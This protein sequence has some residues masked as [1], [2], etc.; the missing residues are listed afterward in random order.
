[1]PQYSSAKILRA[2]DVEMIGI[3]LALKNVDVSKSGHC[4]GE[5]QSLVCAMPLAKSSHLFWPAES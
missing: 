3:G 2:A 1:V 4:L 5:L